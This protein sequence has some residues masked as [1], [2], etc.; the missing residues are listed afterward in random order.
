MD[1]AAFDLALIFQTVASVLSQQRDAFN[2]A[3][4]LNG[5]HGDHMVAIF[6]VANSGSFRGAVGRPG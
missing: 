5:N 4:E 1:P 6:R 3:D 2:Q